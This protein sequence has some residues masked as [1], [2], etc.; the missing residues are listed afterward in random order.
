MLA[1]VRRLCLDWA[2]RHG[3]AH[4]AWTMLPTGTGACIAWVWKLGPQGEP[5]SPSLPI[6]RPAFPVYHSERWGH[7]NASR[8]HKILMDM[9]T[10]T[11]LL[12]CRCPKVA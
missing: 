4:S 12:Q 8:R 11:P 7:W 1:M 5:E 2:Q 9:E 10:P 6:H 3:W